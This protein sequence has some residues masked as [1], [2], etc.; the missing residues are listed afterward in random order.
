MNWVKRATTLDH[1]EHSR[2]N[3]WSGN[4]SGRR[5]A[6]LAQ[7]APANA[8]QQMP[9]HFTKT[10]SF[11]LPVRMDRNSVDAQGD[12]LYAKT[13]RDPG[14]CRKPERRPWSASPVKCRMDGEYWYTLA[15][16][17]S[18]GPDDPGRT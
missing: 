6:R 9:K 17:G 13:R 8:V 18:E 15:N 7:T 10:R 5:A 1:A 12:S 2:G 4:C 16:G 11:D 14:C 3:P